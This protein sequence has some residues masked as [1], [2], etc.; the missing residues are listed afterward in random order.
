M[1]LGDFNIL[2][3]DLD[4]SDAQLFLSMMEAYG[5]D[6]QVHFVTHRVGNC[7]N[8]IFTEHLSCV[9]ITQGAF[10]SDHCWITGTL[11]II[12]PQP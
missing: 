10:L 3:N 1:V 4:D 12:K 6:R 9:N 2:I 8:N 5:F 7:L 11:Q